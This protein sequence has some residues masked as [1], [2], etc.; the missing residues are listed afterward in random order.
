MQAYIDTS[1]VI[2]LI[3]QEPHSPSAIS[4][5]QQIETGWAWKWMR[6]EAEAALIRRKAPPEAWRVWHTLAQRIQWLDAGSDFDEGVCTFNRSIG[7]RA[8]DAG[9]LLV[10]DRAMAVIPSLVLFSFD[11]EMR[12]AA[13]RIGIAVT[14]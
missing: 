14:P 13:Q 5:Q 6:V 9:H 7:L 12:A 11:E 2:P 4:V 10:C 3:L 1:A 8:A